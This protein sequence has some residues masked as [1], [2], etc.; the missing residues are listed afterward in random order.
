[1]YFM[2]RHIPYVRLML[3]L[4]I[5]V[6]AG[7][8][9]PYAIPHKV[10]VVVPVVLVFLLLTTHFI[11]NY[12]WR[13]LS[14]VFI[15]AA[16]FISGFIYSGIS[17]LK[18]KPDYFE[19]TADD[20]AFL[21]VTINEPPQEKEKSYKATA[22]VESVWNN[23]VTKTACGKV[24]LYFSKDS[25]FRVAYGDVILIPVK[26][27]TPI[28]QT[29]NP[30]E[31]DYREFMSFK[32]IHHQAFLRNDDWI[33]L[34]MNNNTSFLSR[35]Y[36]L[37]EHL[38]E[39]LRK[40]VEDPQSFSIASSLLLGTRETLDFHLIRAYSSSG[41]MH[42]LAVSGLHVAILYIMLEKL[43]FFMNR[44]IRLK[45]LRAVII[46]I[47]T[48]GYALLTGFSPSVQ[49]SAI[50]F[51]F[52]SFGQNAGR[53]YNI[54][55]I[56]AASAIFQLLLNPFTIMEVGFQLSYLAVLGIVMFQK[57]FYD[58]IYVKN[59][60]LDYLWQITTVSLAAQLITFP[61]GLLYFYQFP[62]YFFV[63][64]L[65]VIPVSFFIM[66]LGAALLVLAPIPYCGLVLGKLVNW[67]IWVMNT[68]VFMVEKIPYSLIQGLSISIAESWLIYVLI[69]LF[70]AYIHIRNNKIPIAALLIITVLMGWNT[71]E[72]Y[73]QYR[74]KQFVV[75]A[76]PK[77]TYAYDF[78][79][80]KENLLLASE[81]LT[82]NY[83]QMQFHIMHNW[84]EQDVR[85][86]SVWQFHDRLNFINGKI[87]FQKENYIQFYDNRMVVINNK[88][89]KN[90]VQK[91][92]KVDYVI[93]N[94][95]PKMKLEEI[96]KLYDYELIIADGSNAAKNI[97]KWKKTAAEQNINFWSVND[98]GA[99]V[100]DY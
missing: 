58:L 38:V 8:Y 91:K 94:N 14:G 78:I 42:V 43:L 11:K 25:L 27:L 10:A 1:M 36:K 77:Q 62:T 40:Y 6:I 73:H 99:F 96:D 17:K 65:F 20:N 49:R 75:Y 18:F 28:S 2:L 86:H 90:D 47:I 79:S 69:F 32:Q 16:F 68:G 60:I 48:W 9:Y 41:A 98:K 37:R 76:T 35:I 52:I 24:Q 13:W 59:K 85:N 80:G 74:Q 30:H 87:F 23:G 5:G 81:P 21:L 67:S 56:L 54:Y 88:L 4:T 29:R 33:F 44:N 64:N 50:M 66:V 97:R 15:L 12:S 34:S 95:N 7:I 83:S 46:V 45:Q 3:A 53:S 89:P 63:S 57:F 26:K 84:W 72:N 55:N 71:F 93:L 82:E 19:K 51:T 100:L 22:I 61:V 92:L 70:F 39:V 31:F